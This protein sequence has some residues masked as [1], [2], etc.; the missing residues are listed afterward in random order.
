VIG[1]SRVDAARGEPGVSQGGPRVLRICFVSADYHSDST[2]NGR[3]G[4]IATH[5]ATLAWAIAGLGHEVTV[6]TESSGVRRRYSDWEV[7]VVA[8]ARGSRRL[9][10]LGRCLPETI[11]GHGREV[12]GRACSSMVVAVQAD[13]AFGEVIAVEAQARARL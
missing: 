8:V 9:W 12:L 13:E 11:A 10:K 2:G 3:V 7:D 4:G 6:L 5:T 1:S